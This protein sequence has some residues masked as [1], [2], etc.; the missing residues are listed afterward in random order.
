[1]T[2]NCH[3]TLRDARQNSSR[4]KKNS[5]EP[6]KMCLINYFQNVQTRSNFIQVKQYYTMLANTRLLSFHSA[7]TLNGQSCRFFVTPPTLST[8]S[9]QC[10]SSTESASHFQMLWNDVSRIPLTFCVSCYSQS[11]TQLKIN[12]WNNIGSND[13]KL[14]TTLTRPYVHHRL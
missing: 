8:W 14:G 4:C 7:T 6:A 5:G 3:R 12:V 1:M 11:P 9:C 13:A 2:Q 10:K